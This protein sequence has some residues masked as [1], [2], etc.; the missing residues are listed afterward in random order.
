MKQLIDALEDM[1]LP[2]EE[3]SLAKFQRYMELILIWNDKVNLPPSRI[4]G[5]YYKNH[6]VDSV[7]LAALNSSR[8]P[9][10]QDVGT[11]QVFPEFHWRS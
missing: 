10:D 2:Y 6:Y 9:Q 1:G 11:E 5:S 8:S 4:R 7:A 3:D